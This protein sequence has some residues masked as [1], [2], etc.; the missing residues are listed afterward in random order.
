MNQNDPRAALDRLRAELQRLSPGDA[1]ARE[2]LEQLIGEVESHLQDGGQA[3]HTLLA[4]ISDTIRRFEVKH[5]AL[6]AYLGEIAA[7]LS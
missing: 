3:R 7:A 5:P 4:N 6:T 2:H 1:A